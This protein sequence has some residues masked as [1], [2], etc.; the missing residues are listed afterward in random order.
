MT[1]G[2]AYAVDKSGS[3]PEGQDQVHRIRLGR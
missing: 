1:D 2:T 3:G